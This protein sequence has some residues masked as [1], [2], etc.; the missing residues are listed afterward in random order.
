MGFNGKSIIEVRYRRKD[1]EWTL[2]LEHIDGDVRELNPQALAIVIDLP[3]ACA[4]RSGDSPE[5]IQR[6][7]DAVPRMH[8]ALLMKAIATLGLY[9][10]SMRE[11]MSGAIGKDGEEY[12]ASIVI[13][14][15]S[16]PYIHLG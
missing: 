4:V 13:E 9:P 14:R 10:R 3:M 11:V 5:M 12:Y 8:V 7:K 6:K 16:P 2:V 15:V 1:G